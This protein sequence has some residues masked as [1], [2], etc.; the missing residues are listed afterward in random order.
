[1]NN[2]FIL[3]YNKFDKLVIYSTVEDKTL[4]TINNDFILM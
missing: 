2:E 4:C 1:M 3:I